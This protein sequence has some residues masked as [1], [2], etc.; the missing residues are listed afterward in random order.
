MNAAPGMRRSRGQRT[1]A[2]ECVRWQWIPDDIL[3][4]GSDD[5]KVRHDRSGFAA[6]AARHAKMRAR[7][8]S[9]VRTCV[10]RVQGTIAPPA[11]G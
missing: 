10:A 11:G 8:E 7:R 9:G 3:A 5:D 6:D 1:V 4:A 2:E